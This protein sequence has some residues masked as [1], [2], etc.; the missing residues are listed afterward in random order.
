MV[1]LY[2]IAGINHFFNPSTYLSIMM[3]WLPYQIPL[4]Y[5]TGAFE[6]FLGLLLIP[7]ATRRIASCGIIVLLIVIFPANIQMT[8]DYFHDNNPYAWL[9]VLRL[10]LQF[11]L[12]RWAYRFYK[13]PKLV[14]SL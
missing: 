6:I 7:L 12:I 8:L 10:P 3:P 1:L 13:R 2:L 11:V 9:T 4:I 14:S 5:I